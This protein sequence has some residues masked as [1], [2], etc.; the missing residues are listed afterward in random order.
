MG[1]SKSVLN[2]VKRPTKCCDYVM[3]IEHSWNSQKHIS[4]CHRKRKSNSTNSYTG[5]CAN[6]T[7]YACKCDV[8]VYACKCDV[9][10]QSMPHVSLTLKLK[11]RY[12]GDGVAVAV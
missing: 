8:T 10:P 11:L 3:I 9:N 4:G 6:V 12:M 2:L 5:K 1:L 7:V